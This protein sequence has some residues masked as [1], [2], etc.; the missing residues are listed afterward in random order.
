MDWTCR[1][2]DEDGNEIIR[3]CSCGNK[4]DTCI[5]GKEAMLWKCN[6]CLYGPRKTA[7]L[8]YNPPDLQCEW[9]TS[10][11]AYFIKRIKDG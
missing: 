10:L 8:V 6:D 2:E 11:Q 9:G 7:D 1:L 5:M 3:Y 4:G